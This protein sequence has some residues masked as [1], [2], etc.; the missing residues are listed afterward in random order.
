MF[1]FGNKEETKEILASA[2]LVTEKEN[3]KIDID[4]TYPDTELS[5][6]ICVD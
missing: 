3:I 2:K 4:M 5:D 6:G 1:I